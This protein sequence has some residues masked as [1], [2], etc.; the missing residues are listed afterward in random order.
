MTV[1]YREDGVQPVY[2]VRRCIKTWRERPV[3]FCGGTALIKPWERYSLP[4][5]NQL[6]SRFLWRPWPNSKSEQWPRIDNG[7]AA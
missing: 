2:L 5:C 3:S 6:S 4:R 7:N 1:R